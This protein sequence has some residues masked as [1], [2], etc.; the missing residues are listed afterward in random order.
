MWRSML[1][2]R[3][4]ACL[5]IRSGTSQLDDEP[6]SEFASEGTSI[7][8]SMMEG[9]PS[10]DDN[11]LEEDQMRQVD[12][13]QLQSVL[14][15]LQSSTPADV[16]LEP[17]LDDMDLTLNE[18]FVV[19]VLETPLVPGDNLIGFFRWASNKQDF[20]ATTRSVEALARAVSSGLKIKEAYAFWNL[21]QEIGQ[22]NGIL[23]TAILNELISLLSKL[24]K[25]KAAFEVFNKFEEFGCV[26]DSETYYFTIEALCRRSIFDWAWSVCEKMIDSGKLPGREQVG[27]VISYLCKGGKAKDSYL[28]YLSAKEKG[29]YPPRSSVNYLISSLSRNENVHVAL[30][31]LKD[32]SEEDKKYAINPFSSVIRGLCRI[33]DVQGAK[34]LLYKMVDAGPPPGNAVFNFVINSLS[35]AGDLDEARQLM[36]LM[37]IRGLKPDVYTYSVIISG[38]VKGGDMQEACK[39]LDEAKS[40]HSKLSPV[41]YHTLIRGYCKLEEFDKALK[42]LGEMREHGVDPNADEYNKLIQSLCLKAVDWKTA[43]KLHREMEENGLHLNGITKALIRAVKEMEQAEAGTGE[44]TVGA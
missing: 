5:S 3:A 33:R 21:I 1:A 38:Y 19:R 8:A 41:T 17:S 42:L 32:F 37:E 25:G 2:S 29:Q 40:K 4:R 28:V 15:L 39:V 13:E 18:E 31:M 7:D 22:E 23:N 36:K 27:K 14:S 30:E 16:S 10:G 6:S 43:E 9:F 20:S 24:G 34:S 35:K 11:Y 44:V 26:A 12:F